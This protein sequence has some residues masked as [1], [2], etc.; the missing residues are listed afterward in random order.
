MN[1]DGSGNLALGY[2]AGSNATGHNNVFIGYEAGVD[3]TGNS[4]LYVS[5]FSYASSSVKIYF[6]VTLRQE[7]YL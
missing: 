2:K 5:S 4:K 3:E 1:V 7:I 6:T